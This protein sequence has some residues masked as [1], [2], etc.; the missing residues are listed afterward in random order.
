MNS[1]VWS[2]KYP[3]FRISQR[4]KPNV[5]HTVQYTGTVSVGGRTDVHKL[6]FQHIHFSIPALISLDLFSLATVTTFHCWPTKDPAASERRRIFCSLG[7]RPR[8][9]AA[10]AA[11]CTVYAWCIIYFRFWRE[12]AQKKGTSDEFDVLYGGSTIDVRCKLRLSE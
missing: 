3:N 7:I 11:A 2:E 9:G 6:S 1:T 12:R 4:I 8:G 10:S 5:I